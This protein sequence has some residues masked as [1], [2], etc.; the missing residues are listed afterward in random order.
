MIGHKIAVY[1]RLVTSLIIF[2]RRSCGGGGGGGGGGV[3][4]RRRKEK[5]DEN[6]KGEQGILFIF[7]YN[8]N[9]VLCFILLIKTRLVTLFYLCVTQIRVAPFTFKITPYN[10]TSRCLLYTPNRICAD[11]TKYTVTHLSTKDS[12]Q[13][14]GCQKLIYRNSNTQTQSLS[15]DSPFEVS[16]LI[17][18][19]DVEQNSGPIYI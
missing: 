11:R 14:L 13:T 16:E 12:R 3:W 8:Q 18:F 6:E 2:E 4:F 9:K 7:H 17:Y 19:I 10:V 15:K 1:K 5:I